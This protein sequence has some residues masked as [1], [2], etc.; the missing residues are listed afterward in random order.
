VIDYASLTA[1]A[2]VL[3]TFVPISSYVGRG[4]P[5]NELGTTLVIYSFVAFLS[6]VLAIILALIGNWVS[7]V[8]F[9]VGCG[10]ISVV[11]GLRVL[12]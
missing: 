10:A 8:L 11:L 2:A 7:I 12:R 5:G 9:L 6:F 1:A 3:G 4:S